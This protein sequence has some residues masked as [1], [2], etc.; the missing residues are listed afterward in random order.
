MVTNYRGDYSLWKP[1]VSCRE[2]QIRVLS[3][4]FNY[5]GLNAVNCTHAMK[6]SIDF[7][8]MNELQAK[9][10]RFWNLDS[11]GIIEPEKSIYENFESTIAV[12]NGRYEVPL[13][14]KEPHIL[15]VD[16]YSVSKRRLTALKGKFEKQPEIMK[17]YNDMITEQL[18]QGVTERVGEADFVVGEVIYLPHRAVI[19]EVK[20]TPKVRIV[21]DAS[22]KSVG[23]SLND[24][25]YTGP[26]LAPLLYVLI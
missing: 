17:Q 15:L 19:R 1:W 22:V 5:A 25:L 20:S 3:D 12:K 21:Y 11:I 4:P 13:P 26:C 24:C 16:N 7:D 10:D 6:I 8:E 2:L 9:I 23:P 18:Q 14:F